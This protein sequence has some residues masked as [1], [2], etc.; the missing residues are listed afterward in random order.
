MAMKGVVVDFDFAAM[1]GAELLFQTTKTLLEKQGIGFDASLEARFLAG[2]GYLEGFTKLFKFVQT[3]K[4]PQKAAR[5]LETA[6]AGALAKAISAY[7]G[8]AFRNFVS[9]LSEHGVAVV[10]VTRAKLDVVEPMFADLLSENVMLWNDH[11]CVYGNM[12][13]AAWRCS[14]AESNLN[15]TSALAVTGSGFGVRSALVAGMRSVAVMNDHVAW[16]DF[17]GANVIVNDLSAKTAKKVLS[18]LGVE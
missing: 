3:K 4:T 9:V 11:F 2:V 7:A 13:G 18:V 5:D 6:F 1:D 17:S 15:Y 14:C 10:L 12:R 8:K 16:Q